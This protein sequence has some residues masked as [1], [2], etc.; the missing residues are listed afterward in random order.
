MKLDPGVPS[1]ALISDFLAPNLWGKVILHI[2]DSIIYF[3]NKQIFRLMKM[4]N[5]LNYKT[6][7]VILGV[8]SDFFKVF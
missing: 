4:I 3:W 7:Q 1:P 8:S 6:M 5:I 2:M